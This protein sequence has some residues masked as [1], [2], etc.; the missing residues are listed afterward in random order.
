MIDYCTILFDER[1]RVLFPLHINSL[2]Y[3]MPGMFNIK[4]SVRPEDTEGIA[5]CE[6]F[7]VEV[8]QHPVYIQSPGKAHG[9]DPSGPDN[10]N[11]MN[12]LMETC[13][14]PWV[15]H[16]HMDIIWKDNMMLKA[17][18]FMTDEYGVLGHYPHGC[19]AVNRKAFIEC[20]TGFH[21]CSFRAQYWDEEDTPHD[22]WVRL[23]GVNDPHP[24]HH[25]NPRSKIYVVATVDVGVMI[26]IAVQNY[27]Y[28]FNR[29]VVVDYHHVCEGSYYGRGGR[30]GVDG[31]YARDANGSII[32]LTEVGKA[33]HEVIDG[34]VNDA[35][36][37]YAMFRER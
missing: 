33:H 27:S 13:T 34:R 23:V 17:E 9:L 8:L 14:S 10:A 30:W 36:L 26:E 16:S 7:G 2:R 37:K 11:R 1:E 4:V 25:N 28:K 29:G 12:L 5:L 19:M 35:L 21:K 3:Y 20:H 24:P 31:D 32:P 18:Q 15:I 6:S 22:P